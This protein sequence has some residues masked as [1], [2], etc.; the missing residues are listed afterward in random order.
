MAWPELAQELWSCTRIHA[1]EGHLERARNSVLDLAIATTSGTLVDAMAEKLR[2]LLPADLR[3][4]L[5]WFPTGIS[6]MIVE[7]EWLMSF[8]PDIGGKGPHSND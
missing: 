2:P 5:E 4:I 1:R 8:G 3:E 6:T 7:V